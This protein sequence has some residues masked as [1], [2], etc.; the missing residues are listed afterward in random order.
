MTESVLSGLPASVAHADLADG[1]A[2]LEIDATVHPLDAVMAAAYT[3][4]DR[5]YV[6]LDRPSG[7]R[8][9]VVLAPKKGDADAAALRAL[10]GEL[11]NEL[12]S[13]SYRHRIT[14]ENRAL[15]ESVTMRAIAGAMGPPTLDDLEDFDFSSEAFEDPLGIAMAWEEKY[16]KKK[17]DAPAAPETPSEGDEK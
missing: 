17:A 11:G 16:A 15:I 5:A 9:R 2:V 4:I 3:F 8:F 10:V 6:L 1:S 13:A 7:D 12:L 14:A